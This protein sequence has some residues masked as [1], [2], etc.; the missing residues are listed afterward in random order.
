MYAC[1]L[2]LLSHLIL[3]LYNSSVQFRCLVMSDILW[4]H[5]LQHAQPPCP[6]PTPGAD[7][8][9]HHRV[10]D[11]I[12]PS[13]P[14]STPCP[15]A[16]NLSQHRNLFQWVCSLQ[17]VAKYWSFSFSITIS[18]EY[19]GLIFFRIDWFDLLKSKGL[20]RFFSNS[21]VQKHQYSS[22]QLSL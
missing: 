4:P 12:Q 17:Q 7:S 8:N 21:T 9:S 10:G 19:S 22:A 3:Y 14:L 18:N 15:P 5:G 6:S 20:S 13:H 11:T 1:R 2:Y 16:F